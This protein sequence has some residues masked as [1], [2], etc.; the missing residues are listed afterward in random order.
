[1][2]MIEGA[3][4]KRTTHRKSHF[5]IALSLAWLLAASWPILAA[6]IIGGRFEIRQPDG[7]MVPVRIWGDE[8][9]QVVESL[10]G[11]TLIRDP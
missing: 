2:G 11:Y 1:M 10:D 6:P 3:D 9:Y 7:T 8:F 4:V 5:P